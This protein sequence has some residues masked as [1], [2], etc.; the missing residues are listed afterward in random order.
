MVKSRLLTN[1]NNLLYYFGNKEDSVNLEKLNVS[2]KDII[3]AEQIHGN[4]VVLLENS[5]NK[6]IKGAD[7]MITYNRL[8]LSIRTAD[9]MPIFFY[10]PGKK[11]IAAIHAGWKGLSSGIIDNAIKGMKKLGSNPLDL[12]VSVGPHIQ[13]CCYNIPE[14]RIQKF[15]I[16]NNSDRLHLLSNNHIGKLHSNSWY[17]DLGK[18][19][20]S[21]LESSGIIS[22]NIEVS[23]ICTSC[24]SKFW[25]FR[26][27]KQ[28]AGRM[29]NLIGMISN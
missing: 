14:E 1:Y 9:C 2:K 19:A 16:T 18:V 27:D 12:N 21:Q 5:K 13:V 25:S 11:I 24:N 29:I 22:S 28:K 20:L 3:S 17:L 6:F 15:S 10:D 4:K 23:D 26:R 7:G 8:I